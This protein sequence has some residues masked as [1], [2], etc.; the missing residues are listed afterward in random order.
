MSRWAAAIRSGRCRYGWMASR[1]M[2]RGLPEAGRTG[3]KTLR[4]GCRAAAEL[5]ARSA[6]RR[7]CSSTTCA[8]ML[9]DQCWQRGSGFA[10]KEKLSI[11]RKS[12][13]F[14]ERS[15]FRPPNSTFCSFGAETTSV[16]ESGTSA[17]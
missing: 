8:D 13:L 17:E 4:S 12:L 10:G 5:Y 6:L 14:I 2:H 7:G 11:G 9:M 3:C 15:L 16:Q 1:S